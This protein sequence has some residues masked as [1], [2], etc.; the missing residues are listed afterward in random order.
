VA[1][2][3]L[4]SVGLVVLLAG[5]VATEAAERRLRAIGRSSTA[6]PEPPPSGTALLRTAAE[7]PSETPRTSA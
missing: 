6:T 2:Q 3:Q 1:L 7:G 4:L 5:I